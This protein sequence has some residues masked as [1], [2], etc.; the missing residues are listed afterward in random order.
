MHC[1]EWLLCH[2][3]EKTEQRVNG[4]LKAGLNRFEARNNSQVYAARE[5]S[6]AYAEYFCMTEYV[7]RCHQ[8]DQDE[9]ENGRNQSSMRE[10]LHRL[11][12]IYALWCIDRRIANF[13]MGD[14]ASCGSTFADLIRSE[15]LRE[16]ALLKDAAVA[17]AD[18]LAPPDFAL[19]SVIGKSDGQLYDNIWHE[20]LTNSG[21]L[22]RPTWW[23]D[24]LLHPSNK[25]KL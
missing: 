4:D 14:F 9:G 6:L 11:Y 25:S 7:R 23:R 5:L 22:Q 12:R 8:L 15:L 16:C 3:L 20:F 10:I 19:D 24:I 13:Y 21:A 2:L 18:A 1:Y 17:V